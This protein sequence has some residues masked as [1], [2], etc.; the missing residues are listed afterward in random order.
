RVGHVA[1]GEDRPG[2][3]APGEAAQDLG[4]LDEDMTAEV[5]LAAMADLP[6]QPARRAEDRAQGAIDENVPVPDEDPPGLDDPAPASAETSGTAP[7]GD[8]EGPTPDELAA[9]SG[10]PAEPLAEPPEAAETP[11]TAESHAVDDLAED[12]QER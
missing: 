5:P 2:A 10:A 9:E 6:Q 8:L 3:A 12:Q 1:P 4:G 7:V 11:E